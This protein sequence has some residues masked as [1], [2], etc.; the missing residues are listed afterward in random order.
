VSTLFLL[1]LLLGPPQGTGT[2]P[3]GATPTWAPR[4]PLASHSPR[5]VALP[6]EGAPALAHELTLKFVDAARVRAEGRALRSESEAELDALRRLA[7]ELELEFE[8]LLRLAPERV[9]A[10]LDRAR[11]RSGRAQ[12]DLFGLHRVHVPGA[13]PARLEAVARALQT[14]P[15]VEFVH[16]G[17]SGVP[18]PGDIAPPTPELTASQA[19]LLPDPGLGMSELWPAGVSGAGVRISDCEYG[20]NAAHEDLVDVNLHPEPGQTPVP[21]VAALGYDQHGT[22]VLGTLIAPPNGYGVTG[23]VPGATI[24]TY[25]EWTVEGGLRRVECIVS[26][27]AD[28]APGDLV[29]LEMQAQA[30]GFAAFVPAEYDPAVFVAVLAGTD[31]G[32]VVIAAA[33]NGSQNLD[34]PAYAAYRAQGDSGAILVG[35]G[36]STAAHAKLPFSTFGARIDLQGWGEDVLTLGYGGLFALLGDLN[37]AY[38]ADFDG[39]SAAATFAVTAAAAVQQRAR[40][41][42]GA[43]LGPLELRDL[44]KS[45]GIAQGGSGGAIGPFPDPGAAIARLVLPV[46]PFEDLGFALPGSNGTPLLVPNGSMTPGSSYSFDLSQLVPDSSGVQVVGAHQALTPLLGGTLVP[47]PVSLVHGI[48]TGP[49]GATTLFGTVP[50]TIAVGA[51]VIFQYWFYDPGAAQGVSASNAIKILVQ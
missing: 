45:S 23:G 32:V 39:T 12:P 48:A 42:L 22:A 3:P 2:A 7:A 44:L 11:Q 43:P 19:Y 20:W 34:A 33:G 14:L 24:H 29:L 8:P 36:T 21:L 16:L 37:Q 49:T 18:P 35:A 17:V 28:S 27:L 47:N 5:A 13:D 50:P 51:Q 30:P 15:Q 38:E 41:L 10:L 26:A 40:E 25:P 46:S 1:S 4:V 9:E 31:A 6:V